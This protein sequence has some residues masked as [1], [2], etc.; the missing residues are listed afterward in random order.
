MSTSRCAHVA[1]S[2]QRNADGVSGTLTPLLQQYFE[3]ERKHTKSGTINPEL[4]AYFWMLEEFRVSLFAQELKT[5]MPISI[6][7]LEAQWSKISA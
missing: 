7:R 1:K 6:K 2:I 3:R 4:A 5:S